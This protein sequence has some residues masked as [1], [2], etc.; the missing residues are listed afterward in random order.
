MEKCLCKAARMSS[1]EVSGALEMAKSTPS[2]FRPGQDRAVPDRLRYSLAAGY[3]C[4]DLEG[5]KGWDGPSP[6]F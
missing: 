4:A 6:V 3:R 2:A 1:S 5:Q